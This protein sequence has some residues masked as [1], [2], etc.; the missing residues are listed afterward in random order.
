M[1]RQ[2]GDQH[3]CDLR[4]A[5]LADACVD[6][7]AADCGDVFLRASGLSSMDAVFGDPDDKFRD[8]YGLSQTRDR[9]VALLSAIGL[10]C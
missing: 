10:V 8:F 3:G 6:C 1:A 7:D 2:A 5:L 4:S 9:V